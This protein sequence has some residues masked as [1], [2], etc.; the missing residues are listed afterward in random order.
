MGK[1]ISS[2]NMKEVLNCTD[3]ELL[4]F[5]ATE[6]IAIGNDVSSFYRL[7]FDLL[8][9]RETK[10]LVKK[11]HLLVMATWVLAVLTVLAQIFSSKIIKLLF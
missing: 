6:T 4:E 11:T 2:D 7:C 3:Q 1:S 8:Q 9:L 10:K 5:M